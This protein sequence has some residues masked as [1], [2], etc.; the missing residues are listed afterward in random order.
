MIKV[1]NHEIERKQAVEEVSSQL[2]GLAVAQ[3]MDI[4]EKFRNESGIDLQMRKLEY[5]FTNGESGLPVDG[6]WFYR[7]VEVYRTD[8]EKFL[9]L[10]SGDAVVNY[11]TQ[12]DQKIKA[13]D[14]RL[15]D[16]ASLKCTI[17]G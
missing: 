6:G 13:F 4:D 8:Y 5:A 7:I 1:R 14:A 3:G 16:L 11:F 10:L 17:G 2:R 15:E 12:R 9:R